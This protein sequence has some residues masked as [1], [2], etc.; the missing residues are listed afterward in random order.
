MHFSYF[1]LPYIANRNSI[2]VFWLQ[3]TASHMTVSLLILLL[4]IQVDKYGI[5]TK[6]WA[7][8]TRGCQIPTTPFLQPK[9]GVVVHNIDRCINLKG[10][11]KSRHGLKNFCFRTPLSEF[12]DPPLRQWLNM[13]HVVP[14]HVQYMYMCLLMSCMLHVHDGKA[15]RSIFRELRKTDSHLGLNQGPLT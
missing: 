15:Y 7:F 1:W 14:A 4:C 3:Q 5:D 2:Y 9:W 11:T 12:L 13:R 8:D 10:F 6:C